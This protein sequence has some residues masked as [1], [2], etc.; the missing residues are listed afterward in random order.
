LRATA[1]WGGLI[2]VQLRSVSDDMSRPERAGVAV[3]ALVVVGIL[4][5]YVSRLTLP[6]PLFASDEAAYLI[7]ALYPDEMVA[8][9]PYVASANNGVHLSVIRAL[10]RSGAPYI[11]AD[12]LADAAAYLGGLGLLWATVRKRVSPMQ[13][14]ALGLLALGFPYYRFAFS[15]LAEGLYVGVLALLCVATGRWA[16]TRPMLHAVLA[17]VLA[18]ALVLVKPH[19]VTAVAALAVMAVVGAVAS[20]DW[21]RL[22]LRT[23]LFAV[24]FLAAGN[25]IQAGAHEPVIH[26]L[27]FFVSSVYA[28]D[29]KAHT[30]ASAWRL[31]LL[32]LTAMASATLVLAGVP[33]VVGA[34]DLIQRWRAERPAFK[35][36]GPDLIWLLLALSLAATL[37]MATIYGM[38]LAEIPSEIRRLWGRYFEFFAPML[39]L[40]AGPALGRPVNRRTALAA[41][42][43]MLAGLAGLVASLQAGIVIFPWD[44]SILTAF[45][46]SDPVR[47]P[48]GETTPYRALAAAATAAATLLL[49]L[50]VRPVLAGLWLILALG[51]LSTDLDRVW[52]AP[53]VAQRQAQARDAAAIAPA[54]P[55]GDVVVLLTPDVNEGHLMFLLLAARPLVIIGPPAKASVETLQSA[56]EV[57]VSGQAAPPG[58]PWTRTYGGEA[59]SLYRPAAAVP[60]PAGLAATPPL[61]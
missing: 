8:R 38:Q 32:E 39:W 15:N 27:M 19:G 44:C 14:A 16:S 52:L 60:A 1:C 11:L 57:I 6:L 48:L 7:R 42:G 26:P 31:G 47:A 12:R 41:G 46:H 3:A 37:A 23:G 2:D 17:G 45:F 49:A 50:R 34:G 18:A 9:Y 5:F 54:L 53:M 33:L 35:P 10:Y 61:P 4:A 13:G 56:Q 20:G 59:L 24:S 28:N 40:A 51:V 55:A 21:R 25:L 58:G 36:L 29:L 43:A 30:L 22:A